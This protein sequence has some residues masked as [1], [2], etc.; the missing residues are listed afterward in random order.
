MGVAARASVLALPSL[1]SDEHFVGFDRLAFTVA[2]RAKG[3]AR[4]SI[5][6]APVTDILPALAVLVGIG[7][8][9][10]GFGFTRL[11]ARVTDR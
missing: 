1:V 10:G 9:F 8:V 5:D 7:V 11:T 2:H 6:G 4:L 3:A